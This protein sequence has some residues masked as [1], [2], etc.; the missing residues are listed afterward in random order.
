LAVYS[1]ALGKC[2]WSTSEALMPEDAKEAI[3]HGIHA[4][5]GDQ[6]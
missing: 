5:R 1:A 4:K 6:S 2:F 3:G